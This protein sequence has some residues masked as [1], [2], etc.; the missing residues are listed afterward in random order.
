M[1]ISCFYLVQQEENKESNADYGNK[2]SSYPLLVRRICLL[3]DKGGEE[4]G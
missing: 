2:N 4:Y 3:Q 1:I